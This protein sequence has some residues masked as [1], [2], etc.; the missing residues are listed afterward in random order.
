MIGKALLKGMA[1]ER[2]ASMDDCVDEEPTKANERDRYRDRSKRSRGEPGAYSVAQ[3][4][5][6]V[7]STPKLLL[8]S[9]KPL[10]IM[11]RLTINAHV[12]R[13]Q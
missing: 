5:T 9:P 6:K 1:L 7:L 3:I 11:T 10:R 12:S 2:L 8:D 13:V 4:M